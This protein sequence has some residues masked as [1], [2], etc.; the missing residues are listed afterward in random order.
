M[1]ASLEVLADS[2]SVHFTTPSYAH[3]HFA[4]V[5]NVRLHAVFVV[6]GLSRCLTPQCQPARCTAAGSQR[7]GSVGV[8]FSLSIPPEVGDFV[9]V[10]HCCWQK[11]PN[12]VSMGSNLGNR[13]SLWRVGTTTPSPQRRPL[14]RGREREGKEQL[15][16]R[17]LAPEARAQACPCA[18][19][20]RSSSAP[21]QRE[22]GG[23]KGAHLSVGNDTHA[24][25]GLSAERKRREG[26]VQVQLQKR[27]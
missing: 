27:R 13:C 1:P 17:Y 25:G 14:S 19:S 16:R 18:S 3:L 12:D 5:P 9:R 6:R 15:Q 4:G 22:R 24:S 21:L 8:V 26:E 23:G 7:W 10:G 20:P 11:P 2:C